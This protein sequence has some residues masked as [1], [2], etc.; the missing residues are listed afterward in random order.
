MSSETKWWIEC[1]ANLPNGSFKRNHITTPQKVNEFRFKH[2]NKGVFATAYI[3]DSKE[4]TEANIYG[5]FYLDFDYDINDSE[6]KEAAFDFVRKD[7]IS[8]VRYLKIIYGIQK[9]DLRLYFSGSKGVHL[10]VPKEVLGVVPDKTLNMVYRSMAEDIAKTGVSNLDLRIYDNRR[11]FRL[12]NSIH[13]KTGLYKIPITYEEIENSTYE[14]IRTIAKNPRADKKK[15]YSINQAAHM[16]YMNH[17]KKVHL[18]MNKPRNGSVEMKL[19]FTPPCVDY[20]LKN[21]CG[22]GQR[23]DTL[24]FL[25]SFCKQSGMDMDKATVMLEQWNDTLCVPSMP[26]REISTTVQSIYGG[27]GNMGCAR[28]KM[29]SVCNK[30]ECKL[31]RKGI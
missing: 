31:Y 17:I 10:I 18:I 25:A 16:E 27:N 3:Y 7:V 22:K 8:A 30:D 23:N 2:D 20:L 29:I 14:Q 13:P 11:L 28:A 1:G 26:P 4:Q 5:D 24:A 21:Q 12:P 9:E 6:D 19:D 15:E